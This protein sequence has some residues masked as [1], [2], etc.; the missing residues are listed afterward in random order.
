M[1]NTGRNLG[2][3]LLATATIGSGLAADKTA[4]ARSVV[5]EGR[6]ACV[7][8]FGGTFFDSSAITIQPG[9]KYVSQNGEGSWSYSA[10]EQQ[11][12]FEN[13]TLARDFTTATY[14]ASGPVQGGLKN[15]KGP[16]MVLKPSAAYKK[17]HGAEAV[18][19][20]CYLKTE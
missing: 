14:V 10:A 8:N 11:I 2:I 7:F 15:K 17:M 9:N 1:K 13:G 6:Y 5:R 20:Y 12:K 19:L 16:A 4:P 3:L 18:P